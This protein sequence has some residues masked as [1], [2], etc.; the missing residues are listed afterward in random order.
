M[1]N[2]RRRVASVREVVTLLGPARDGGDWD[3]LDA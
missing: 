1:T 2:C 3:I